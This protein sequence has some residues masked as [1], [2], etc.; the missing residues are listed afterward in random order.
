MASH[1]AITEPQPIKLT[2]EQIQK[3]IPKLKRRLEE[4][5]KFR[6]SSVSPTNPKASVTPLICAIEETIIEIFGA[7]TVEYQ[8]YIGAAHFGWPIRIRRGPSLT[9]EIPEA[10][11]NCKQSSMALLTSAILAMEERLEDVDKASV[12]LGETIQ[13]NQSSPNQKIFLVHG[14]DQAPLNAIARFLEKIELKPIILHERPNQGKTIIEKFEANSDV[15]FAI[16]IL[17]PDDVGGLTADKIQPRAR[18]NVILEL[19]Y[20]TGKLGRKNVCAL[21][22]GEL[23]LPSD[24][25]GVAWT[26]FD[27]QGGWKAD[28][29]KEL[30][31]AGHMIDWNKVM[32]E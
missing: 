25:I 16:V 6:P 8:R 32:E 31:A 7:N 9:H 1:S 4:V 2:T 14:H 12:V 10:L 17:T 15:G 29:A 28:L 26:N 27:N 30:K 23:E 11:E 18:Q 5:T 24:V 22:C 3:A 13:K 19:G 21:K 20:F